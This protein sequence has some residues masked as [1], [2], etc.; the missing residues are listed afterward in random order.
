MTR[1]SGKLTAGFAT[2]GMGFQLDGAKVVAEAKTS[3]SMVK[4]HAIF[5]KLER[6][7][8]RAT[9]VEA[10][11]V[12]VELAYRQPDLAYAGLAVVEPMEVWCG[13]PRNMHDEDLAFFGLER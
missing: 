1:R 8:E 2:S 4:K 7:K 6:R 10:V 3:K 9:K 5:S 13:D 12:T 11:Q